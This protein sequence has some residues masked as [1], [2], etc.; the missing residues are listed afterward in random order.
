MTV[1]DGSYHEVDSNEISF[2]IAGRLALRASVE[3]ARPALLEPILRVEIQTP[4]AFA[5]AVMGDLNGRRGRVLGMDS[6]GAGQTVIQAE[7]PMAEML[8]YG[9]DLV[10]MTQ[11]HGSFHAEA[12][13]YDF[14]PATL[15]DKV[16]AASRQLAHAAVADEE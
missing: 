16:V 11:G 5:G 12:D 7:V 8:T 4:E 1:Y 6:S 14:L 3:Q 10:A 2:R 9:V 15:Q 13:H